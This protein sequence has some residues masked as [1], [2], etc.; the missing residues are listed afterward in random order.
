MAEDPS[1]RL[2]TVLTSNGYRLNTDPRRLGRL[3][4]VPT[5]ERDDREALRARLD[6]DG[7]LFLPGFFDPEMVLRFRA[8]Y[9]AALAPSGLTRAGSDP[10]EGAAADPADLDRATFRHILFKQVV[11]GAE[12]EALCRDPGLVAF[13]Q[14]FLG[15]DELH[16]HRRKIIRH[17]GPGEAGVGAATQAHYDLVYLREGTDRV[18]SSWIPLGDCPI[19]RGPLIYLE[20]SHHKVREQ[21]AAG[22]LKRPAASLT[23]DLPALADEY[24]ARWLVADFAAGDLLVHNAHIVHASLDNRDPAGRFRLSTDIRYQPAAEPV[25]QRWQNHWHDED[26]L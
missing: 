4:P 21:E 22:T 26:G 18:V 5:A 13:Y 15:T 2:S 10:V 25:D 6:R 14:W 8:H 24:D 17:V 19:E 20:G 16:L 9:F 12:Y 7:Y 23:A 1:S 11:P 3:Q